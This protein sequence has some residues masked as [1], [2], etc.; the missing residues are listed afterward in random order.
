M[1][2]WSLPR[3]PVCLGVSCQGMHRA[4]GSAEQAAPLRVLG[5]DSKATGTSGAAPAEPAAWRASCILGPHHPGQA[6]PRAHSGPRPRPQS[7]LHQ[8]AAAEKVVLKWK[9]GQMRSL[10]G[11]GS[12]QKGSGSDSSAQT[13]MKALGVELRASKG[14]GGGED[15]RRRMGHRH[16]AGQRWVGSGP[17]GQEGAPPSSGPACLTP[18]G[19][20]SQAAASLSSSSRAR[21]WCLMGLREFAG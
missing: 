11:S 14:N 4:T 15:Q 13:L 19:P 3:V 6:P 10:C 16:H 1:G 20:S 9:P 8:K 2:S 7:I 21:A 17:R 18:Q 12:S 5:K